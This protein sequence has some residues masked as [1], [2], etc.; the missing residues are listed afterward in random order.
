LRP[1]L[2]DLESLSTLEREIVENELADDRGHG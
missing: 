1:D 2:L